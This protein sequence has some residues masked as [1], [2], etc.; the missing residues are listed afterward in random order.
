LVKL[1]EKKFD[2][3]T[4]ELRASILSFYAQM[5]TPDAHG[6]GPQLEALKASGTSVDPIRSPE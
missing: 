2:G 5:K 1:A 6:I 4:P 3:V